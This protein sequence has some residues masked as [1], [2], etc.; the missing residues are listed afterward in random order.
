[1]RPP[2]IFFLAGEV[3][4]DVQAAHLARAIRE[5][6]PDARLVGAGGPR[7]AEAGVEVV[8]DTADWG[9]VG[10]I[11]AYIRIPVFARRLGATLRRI[12]DNHPDVLVLVDFPGFNL[13]V[14]RRVCRHIPTV[15]YFPPMAHGRRGN[16]AAVLSRLPVRV[17]VPFAFELERYRL[18][19]A[20]VTFV[21]H[22]AVDLVRPTVPREG[23]CREFGLDP[24]RP[25]V[26]LLPGS[27]RQEVDALLPAMLGAVEIAAA[28][29]PGVQAAIALASE[30][31]A[32][33]VVRALRSSSAS[34]AVVERRT[35][36]LIGASDAA[37]V[38]SGTATLEAALL[39]VPMVIT[40]RVSRLTEWIARRIVTLPWIG[41]PNILAGR[42]IVPEL[43]QSEARA[44]RVA[45]ELIGLL[46]DRQRSDRMRRDM[47]EAVA[48]LGPA[49][50][51]GRAAAE[52]VSAIDD[53]R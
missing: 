50:A 42:L 45:D 34:P 7:M 13:Q 39:G 37:V 47:K 2:T 15:Y 5:L 22:P 40:Y 6:R 49:G 38:A 12:A 46:A 35:Y 26:A 4:G 17:L 48:N 44:D 43:L 51:L 14:A 1:L 52:V 9:V 18:A 33:R 20:D 8:Q 28:R 10:Y 21:G 27:R 23:F 19:G 25:L 3:S 30:Q 16:R 11:E 53:P 29:V 41:M 32:P 31:L 36:D 24:D